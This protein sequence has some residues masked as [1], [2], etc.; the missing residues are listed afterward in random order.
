[1]CLAVPMKVVKVNGAEGVVA[2]GNLKR[3]VN[4]ALLKDVKAG[5]Y[6]LLHAGFAIA[7]VKPEEAR[8]TIRMINEL[9]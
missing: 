1:M 6:I 2:S 8:Q 7:K 5:D 4:F 3:K 9:R